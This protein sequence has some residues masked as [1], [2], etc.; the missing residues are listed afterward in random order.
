MTDVVLTMV[1][2]TAMPVLAA[3]NEVVEEAS[4]ASE[5]TDVTPADEDNES[6]DVKDTGVEPENPTDDEQNNEEGGNTEETPGDNDTPVIETP[7]T[8]TPEESPEDPAEPSEEEVVNPTTDPEDPTVPEE[9]EDTEDTNTVNG[10]EVDADEATYTV[11]ISNYATLKNQVAIEAIVGDTPAKIPSNGALTVTGDASAP[12][13]TSLTLTAKPGYKITEVKKGED[14]VTA[15]GDGTY[16]IPNLTADTTISVTTV[17]VYTISLDNTAAENTSLK[18]KTGET[19]TTVSDSEVKLERGELSFTVDG[20]TATADDRLKVYYVEDGSSDDDTTEIEGVESTT[21]EGEAAVTTT[22]YTVPAAKI[23]ALDES[24]KIILVKETKGTVTFEENTKVTVQYWGKKNDNAAAT[25]PAEAW[26]VESGEG[27]NNTKYDKITKAFVGDTFKFKVTGVDPW[28]VSK[29]KI[30][31]EEITLQ[32]TGEYSVTVT[33]EMLDAGNPAQISFETVYDSAKSRTLTYTLTGDEGSATAKITSVTPAGTEETPGTATTTDADMA[34]ALGIAEADLILESGKAL[35][36]LAAPTE[37]KVTIAPV[38]NYE[39]VAAT[40]ETLEENGSLVKTYTGTSLTSAIAIAATTQE[41]ALAGSDSKYFKA[42]IK[43]GSENLSALTLV[44]NTNVKPA[45]GEG[46]VGVYEVK[47]GARNVAF[48]VTAKEGFK[49]KDLN[50]TGMKITAGTPAANGDVVYT[51]AVPVAMITGADVENAT[52]IEVEEEAITLTASKKAAEGSNAAEFGVVMKTKGTAEGDSFVTYTEGDEIAFGSAFRATITP[53]KGCRLDEVSYVMGTAAAVTVPVTLNDDD[54]PEVLIEIPKM[55]GNVT[56]TVKSGKDY[57]LTT[58]TDSTGNEIEQDSD[59]I[60]HVKYGKKY[61]VGVQQGNADVP[62]K[63]VTVVVKDETG[64]TVAMSNPIISGKRSINL[65][66]KNLA[67]QEIT[68][69]IFVKGVEN[70]V[71][72]YIMSVEK[73]TT[74]ITVN[75]GNAIAQSVDSVATYDLTTDGDIN[76]VSA[77]VDGDATLKNLIRPTIDSKTGK[78][79]VAV[80]PASR[81]EIATSAT[82]GTGAEAVTTWTA[83]KAKI[84]V[85]AN[86]DPEVEAS[87][88]ITL[89]ALFNEDAAPTVELVDAADTVLNVKVGMD[90]VAAPKTGSVWYKVTATAKANTPASGDTPASNRPDNMKSPVT[91]IVRKTGSSNRVALQVA[92]SSNLGEGAEW[93]YDVTA[94][95]FYMDTNVKPAASVAAADAKA[96]SKEGKLEGAAT[97]TPLFEDALKLKK[98]KGAPAKLYTGQTEDIVIAEPQWTKKF[99]SYKIVSDQMYDNYGDFKV[100][101]NEDGNIILK[102]GVPVNAHLGKHTITVVATADEYGKDQGMGSSHTTY[103]SRATISVNVVKGINNIIVNQPSENIYKDPKK[104]GT[105][106]L[107][108]TY[109]YN[110]ESWNGKKWISAP[111]TKKVTWSIVDANS[112]TSNIIA[113]PAYL[114]V[115]DKK[116][117]V[118]VKNG[119][120][121]VAKGFTRD[122][123]HAN[124]NQFKVLVEAADFK[125]NTTK[126]LSNTITITADALDISTLVIV[127]ENEEDDRFVTAV[128]DIKDKKPVEVLA[129][130]VDGGYLYA[131]PASAAVTKGAKWTNRLERAAVPMENLTMTATNKKI[132]TVDEDG[133]L[134]VLAAGKKA[135]VKVVTN[136]GGKK[137]HTMTLTLGYKET[138]GSDLALGIDYRTGDDNF[139][140]DS[141]NIFAPTGANVAKANK[142]NVK[143]TPVEAKFTATGAARL[144]VY[145]YIGNKADGTSTAYTQPADKNFTNYKLAVKGGKAIYNKMGYATI[146]TTAKETTLTLTDQTKEAK[147]AKKKPYVYKIVNE[148]YDN[149]KLLKAPKVTVKGS[150]YGYGTAK[151]QNN[152]LKLTVLNAAERNAL[153]AKDKTV[154]VELDWSARTD[155]NARMLNEFAEY[156]KLNKTSANTTKLGETGIVSLFDGHENDDTINLYVGSYKLKVT[157]GHG[158]GSNF[159]AETLPATINVKVAKLKAFTFKPTTTYTIN[160]IDGGAVLTGKSNVNVKAGELT[161]MNFDQ[162][163]NVNLKGKSNKFTHY[164]KIEEDPV[165][166]TQRLTL[167]TDDDL[168]K[169]M[170]YDKKADG[171]PDLNKPLDDPAIT[172]PKED[173]TGYIRYYAGPSVNYYSND[174]VSGTVK[175]TVKIAPEVKPGKAAKPSQKY[176]ANRA[177][178]ALTANAATEMNV[179]VNGAYVSIA[180]AMVDADKKGNAEELAVDLAGNKKGQI[181]LKTTKAVEEGKTYS[182]NLLIVPNS[183]F[184]KTLID[185]ATAAT[186]QDLIKKY[187]IAIKVSVLASKT[188]VKTPDPT[189]VGGG[190]EPEVK[191]AAQAKALL[192]AVGNW[193][194]KAQKSDASTLDESK[195]AK[196]EEDLL[197]EVQGKLASAGFAGEY[198][199]TVAKSTATGSDL[200]LSDDNNSATVKFDVTVNGETE[201]VSVTIAA[202]L[203]TQTPEKTATEVA[204]EIQTAVQAEVDKE[205]GSAVPAITWD[206]TQSNEDRISNAAAIKTAIDTAVTGSGKLADGFTASKATD[207]TFTITSEPT[208]SATG[209]ATITLTITKT[210]DSTTGTVTISLTIPVTTA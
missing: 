145:L 125:G 73:K 110:V 168:V 197:A 199:A 201:V 202:E 77:D 128:H 20:Y 74:A 130:D 49:L 210:A 14:A 16:S 44:A 100:D 7:D 142:A 152:A 54:Q 129:S 94:Q 87:V 21:G 112:T 69:D 136:D 70:A 105:L 166:D 203:A 11:T 137:T 189:P 192:E 115:N 36:V 102:G 148:A 169:A 46:S 160:K 207:A 143:E 65:A 13:A 181:V 134:G 52:V 195:T 64:A 187:G 135:G 63:D 35:S 140:S 12:K 164:F 149:T 40:G 72:T 175:I 1:P 104:A 153:F 50:L 62:A 39:L 37:I 33:E 124:N 180:Y 17:A 56:I 96:V 89:T 60:Y 61:L 9:P 98:A 118:S 45:T 95:L 113:A 120:V 10:A 131:L 80:D 178:V 19:T 139:Y 184:Y 173:L 109:N 31:T 209:T 119:T 208:A 114:N 200:T 28:V 43:D 48:T 188:P 107:G 157:V 174:S 194:T 71:G 78:L 57:A 144:D 158:D 151:E 81:D 170:L 29:V 68:A 163:Q 193:T 121:T 159:V 138:A 206:G 25:D 185:K 75:G 97:K 90:E 127:H 147:A 204:T 196:T 162:L 116:S 22:T 86:D 103:A 186:Q 191:T 165:T 172:I 85:S 205:T 2:Q 111:A 23:N 108:V 4:E 182:T 66:N 67:G 150:L 59:K 42:S 92:D 26:V 171:T 79:Q 15:G 47:P 83:K 122:E 146:I 154:K 133:V 88:E 5:V 55:T 198:A 24:L 132:L 53:A 27:A 126:A 123:R 91:E 117:G 106:K 156:L 38:G 99:N 3:E 176:A 179:I 155:K 141:K 183:S 101:V 34:A 18:V 93:S 84:T 190:E 82:T 6:A 76:N 58:L 51:V 177:E 41:K 167:N 32:T 8:E 161:Y 30:G